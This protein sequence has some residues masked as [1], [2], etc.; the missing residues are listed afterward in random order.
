LDI[1]SNQSAISRVTYMEVSK[2]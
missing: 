1:L 2:Y